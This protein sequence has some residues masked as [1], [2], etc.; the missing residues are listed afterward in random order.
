MKRFLRSLAGWQAIICLVG[1][2]VSLAPTVIWTSPF[3]G[4]LGSWISLRPGVSLHTVQEKS[5]AARTGLKVG[6]EILAVNETSVDSGTQLV[7]IWSGLTPG[8]NV[9]VAH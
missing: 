6:D 2:C 3:W 1:A 8:R 7:S 4:E 9:H 5:P